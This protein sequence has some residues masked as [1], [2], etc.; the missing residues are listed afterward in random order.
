MIYLASPYSHPDPAVVEERYQRTLEYTASVLSDGIH[1]YSPIVHC[2]VLKP[3]IT[4]DSWEFWK[5]HDAHMIHLCEELHV[6]TLDGWATSVGVQWELE[7]ARLLHKPIGFIHWNQAL[8]LWR[9]F[10]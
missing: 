4:D 7:F 9:V 6:L 3:K 2:H 1:I 8:E 5:K 10:K